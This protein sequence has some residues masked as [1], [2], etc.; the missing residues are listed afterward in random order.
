MFLHRRS[1]P[2]ALS[3]DQSLAEALT[4]L[5][6]ERCQWLIATHR[7]V[8]WPLVAL[9]LRVHARCSADS[10]ALAERWAQID[11]ADPA[12]FRECLF[13]PALTVSRSGQDREA[14]AALLGGKLELFKRRCAEGAN[15]RAVLLDFDAQ[16]MMHAAALGGEPSC[17]DWLARLFALPL[18]S[19]DQH[20][21][22]PLHLA[23]SLG[24]IEAAARLLHWGA[25]PLRKDIHGDDL[26]AIATSS[27]KSFALSAIESALLDRDT[28][29][30]METSTSRSPRL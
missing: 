9:S 18:D 2:P 25:N 30:G 26:V 28:R 15:E 22:T 27:C 21:L 24:H 29:P 10:I 4:S 6:S 7:H 14:F 1:A 8:N 13:D 17:I 23:V 20:G 19:R 12:L 16:T 11:G 5:N 3:L